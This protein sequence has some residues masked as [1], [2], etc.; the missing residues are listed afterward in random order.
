[1]EIRSHLLN[2]RFKFYFILDLQI[3]AHQDQHLCEVEQ[4]VLSRFCDILEI[5]REDMSFLVGL[6][7]AVVERDP[8]AKQ[9]WVDRFLKNIKH[10]DEM[11][12]GAA[13]MATIAL[14]TNWSCR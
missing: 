7:D 3:M 5:D 10:H 1:M 8:D 14:C 4:S 12:C 13:C 9:Q 2:S 11:D 6:A